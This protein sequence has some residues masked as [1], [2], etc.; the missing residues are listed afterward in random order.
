MSWVVCR[1]RDVD[2][3]W[4]VSPA[5]IE[6]LIVELVSIHGDRRQVRA[7]W[8]YLDV[9]KRTRGDESL[10]AVAVEASRLAVVVEKR[11][12][13]E[14]ETKEVKLVRVG[15]PVA[16]GYS[17]NRQK[18]KTMMVLMMEKLVAAAPSTQLPSARSAQQSCNLE[19]AFASL[20]ASQS[21][22]SKVS[23]SRH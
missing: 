10:K 12:L 14:M 7:W 15:P 2:W 9:E 16:L 3:I 13:P 19:P 17:D 4:E 18:P 23:A 5:G 20:G 11:I 22:A 1:A 6:S 8:A 21:R